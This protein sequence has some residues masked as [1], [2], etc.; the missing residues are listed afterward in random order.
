MIPPLDVPVLRGSRVRLEPLA[1]KHAPDLARAAEEDRS[2]Y[3]FTLVPRADEMETFVHTQLARRGVTP[4]A[5]VRERDGSAVGCT[6]FLDPRMWPGRDELCAIEVGFTWLAA[7]AQRTGINTE[8]KLL[9]F[10]HAFEE[11]GVARVDL[12]TDARN[13]RSRRAIAGVGARFEGVLRN[14]QRSWAPGED[15]TLR[16]SAMFSVVSTEWPNVKTTLTTRLTASTQA[17]PLD[18]TPN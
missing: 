8:A 13:R 2:A 14:W 1:L 12:K 7:S 3:A 10:T 11:L 18:E 5:Q 17:G 16:D 6:A 4:F 9:L 15:D